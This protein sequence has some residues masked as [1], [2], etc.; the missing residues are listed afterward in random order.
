MEILTKKPFEL[1]E[2]NSRIH[3]T[4]LIAGWLIGR[5]DRTKKTYSKV[6]RSFFE[7]HKRISIS[8]TTTAHITTFL[9][10]AEKRGVKPATLNLYLNALASLFRHALKQRKIE[11][12]PTQGLKNYRVIDNFHQKVLHIDEINQM[13]LKTKRSRDRLLIK[14]LFYLGIR[15]SEAT[16]IQM[17]DFAT[18]GGGVVLYIKGKGSKI[19]QM[20]IDGE[21]WAE[22]CEYAGRLEIKDRNYLFTDEKDLSR[23]LSPFSLWKAVSSAGKRAKVGRKVHPHMFRHTSATMA[24]SEGAPI[25]VVQARLGHASLGST[26]K[27]L[28][29]NPSDGLHRYL[30]KIG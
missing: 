19:R 15:V 30:P 10:S 1:N 29:A 13:L 9:K 17:T 16:D 7:Y 21:F 3:D 14:T 11:S 23:R 18:S 20:P 5:A 2:F 25:H 24:M 12:D 8:E 28:H 22:I 26:Q 4:V 6:L 27:Y